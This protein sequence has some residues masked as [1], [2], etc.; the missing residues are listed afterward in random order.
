MVYIII[1]NWQGADDTIACLTSLGNLK[2]DAFKVI[3]CDNNSQDDSW[4][5][6]ESYAHGQT[7]F[8]LSLIQTGANLGF[9]GGNN[10]G[11]QI[12]L[13]DP[14]MEFVWVLN[15][16]TEVDSNALC[17]LMSH[18][19][20][21]PSVGICGSTLLYMDNP[22]LIQAVGGFYNTWLGTSRH[23]LGHQT[24][25]PMLCNRVDPSQLDYVVGASMFVRRSVLEEIGLLSDDYF[26]Y[27]EEIDWATRMKRQCAEFKLGYAPDSLVY[28]KEGSSTGSN[29][30][31]G[32]TYNYLADYF[33]ISSRLK[34]AQKFFPLKRWF[35]QLSMIVVAFNRLKRRQW[36]SAGLALYLFFGLKSS[37]FDPRVPN[38]MRQP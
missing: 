4:I 29:E 20:N 15:N 6:L 35:V 3:V 30:R 19:V 7:K 13:T 31:N 34:Y 17:A 9:A 5:K 32:K 18:M 22:G 27:C 37:A 8:D 24:Y 14:E 36:R 1:L 33:L 11:L 12:A 28:H 25:S 2:S 38:L 10:V 23:A 16:D 26:L 21:N